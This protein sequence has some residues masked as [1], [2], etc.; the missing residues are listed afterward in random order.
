MTEMYFDITGK[1]FSIKKLI[2]L[3]HNPEK[4]VIWDKDVE[5]ARIII[6]VCNGKALI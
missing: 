3:I 1:D 5:F 2:S 6:T 4:R